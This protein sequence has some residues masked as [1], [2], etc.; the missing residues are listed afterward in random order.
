MDRANGPRAVCDYA[1]AQA[2]KAYADASRAL[3]RSG[4][5][6]EQSGA[7][8]GAGAS[9]MCEAAGFQGGAKLPWPRSIKVVS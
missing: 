5:G 1:Y 2:M 8:C 4:E 9:K 6:W 7:G 3:G